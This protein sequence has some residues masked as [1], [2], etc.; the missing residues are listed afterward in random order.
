MQAGQVD[1]PQ[2]LMG[3]LEVDAI[4]GDGELKGHRLVGFCHGGFTEGGSLREREEK[5]QD[6]ERKRQTRS[7]TASEILR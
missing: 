7:S 2:S 6:D 4:G 5:N 1:L 3:Q